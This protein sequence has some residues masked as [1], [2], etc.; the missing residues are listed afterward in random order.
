MRP[1]WAF[2]GENVG[3]WVDNIVAHLLE[4]EFPSLPFDHT[5]L[6]GTLTHET[7]EAIFRAIVQG[8]PAA[9][10]VASAYGPPLGLSSS[11]QPGVFDPSDGRIPDA[12]AKILASGSG[13]MAA[14]AL[15]DLLCRDYGLN[16]TLATLYLLAFVRSSGSGVRLAQ[17][18]DVR[19]PQG[20]PF[21]SDW[22]TQDLLDD[23]RFS[24]S[25]AGDMELASARPALTWNMALPYASLLVDGLQRA[26]GD[27]EVAVQ[28]SRLVAGLEE[29]RLSLDEDRD[30]VEGLLLE[31]GR[32][33]EPSLP[34]LIDGLRS[35]CSAA[36]FRS[37]YAVAVDRFGWPAALA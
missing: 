2:G 30:R 6:P 33:G 28:E 23:I 36:D 25:I 10:E 14:R 22:I 1:S 11:V 5:L 8:D 16:Y 21:V 4:A 9:V 13:E 17:G 37:F 12:I 35:L 15:L 31:L 24:D 7:A 18:H 34:E 27:S 19:T 26:E 20:E 32:A 29:T 3:S